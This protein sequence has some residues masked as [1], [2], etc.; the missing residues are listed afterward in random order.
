MRDRFLSSS[1]ED[2]ADFKIISLQLGLGWNRPPG[3]LAPSVP[4]GLIDLHMSFVLCLS[5][6]F[7][8][9]D[10]CRMISVQVEWTE[11]FC[12]SPGMNIFEAPFDL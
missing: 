3:H 1:Q 7:P 8:G 9:N 12:T 11:D 2:L 4:L 10:S 5:L 6:G